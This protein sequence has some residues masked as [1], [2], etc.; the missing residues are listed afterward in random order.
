[1]RLRLILPRVEPDEITAPTVCAHQNCKGKYLRLHQQVS[2][3]IR[4]TKHQE[5]IAHRYQCLK[6]SRT[7]RVYPQGVS[8]AQASQ[9][10]AVWR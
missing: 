9:H 8:R 3:A 6:C 2:K 1:M 4:D 7:F 10:C 5:V